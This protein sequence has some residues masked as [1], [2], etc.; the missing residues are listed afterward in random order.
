MYCKYL[1]KMQLWKLRGKL[2]A[3]SIHRIFS[4]LQYIEGL[5]WKGSKCYWI[6]K[7][8]EPFP[9][10]HLDILIHTTLEH[11]LMD[12]YLKQFDFWTDY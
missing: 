4:S 1:I 3:I 2:S 5:K 11:N 12:T 10:R 8:I 6:L 7:Q 9:N